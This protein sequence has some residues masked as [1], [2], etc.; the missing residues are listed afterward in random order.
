MIPGTATPQ[1]DVEARACEVCFGLGV[2]ASVCACPS[3]NPEG[4][5]HA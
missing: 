5:N 1:T 2:I 3:C 4:L